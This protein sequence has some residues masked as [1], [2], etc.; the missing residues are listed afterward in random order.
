MNL[1]SYLQQAEEKKIKDLTAHHGIYYDSDFSRSWITD[2]LITKLTNQTYLSKITTQQLTPS[3][4]QLLKKLLFQDAINKKDIN[5]NNYYLLEDYGLIYEQNNCCYL[6]PELQPLLKKIYS[7]PPDK[8]D[9]S[10]VKKFNLNQHLTKTKN[11][12]NLSFF[13]YLVLTIAQ[14]EETPQKKLLTTTE[15]LN[16]LQQINTTNLSSQ[17]LL[18]K[19]LQYSTTQNLISEEGT[20]K[21]EFHSWLHTKPQQRIL[22][23]INTFFPN[24]ASALRNIIAVLSH[25]PLTKA[26][27]LDFAQQEL[28]LQN[29]NTTNQELLKLFN[30]INIQNQQITLK[31]QAWHHFNP[32]V[33]FKFTPPQTEKTKILVAPTAKL[34]Q[35]WTIAKANKLIS[36]DKNFVFARSNS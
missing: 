5:L 25:Y 2:Q 21:S 4:K 6:F 23:A 32:R 33:K 27:P 22:A 18:Q 15:T 12:L 35:L 1:K 29:F 19:L 17:F 31:K 13:H 8:P 26:I 24:S 10:K 14:L 9:N 7:P 16:F 28:Q 11:K 34:E 3:S 20:L 36:I 30:I